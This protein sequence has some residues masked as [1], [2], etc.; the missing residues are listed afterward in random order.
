M[1]KLL[2]AKGVKIAWEHTH[3]FQNAPVHIAKQFG[4][5][6]RPEGHVCTFNRK[7]RGISQC[8]LGGK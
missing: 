1:L 7:S 8:I 2:D 3:M 4:N 6:C 5:A